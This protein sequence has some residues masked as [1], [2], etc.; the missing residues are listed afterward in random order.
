MVHETSHVTSRS[1]VNHFVITYT[2][3][4][5]AIRI[6]VF[7]NLFTTEVRMSRKDFPNILHNKLS[8]FNILSC[9]QPPPLTSTIIRKHITILLILK[10][11]IPTQIPHWTSHSITLNTHHPIKTTLITIISLSLSQYR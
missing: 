3:K 5:C 8:L 4:I 1:R 6:L 2:H 7:L 11:P 9:K 10:P